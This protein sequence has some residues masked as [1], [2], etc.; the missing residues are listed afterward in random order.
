MAVIP[1]IHIHN[2]V[3]PN[4]GRP[5]MAGKIAVIG[6]FDS[7][8]TT[9]QLFYSLREAKE[10]LGTD[11]TFNGCA[12]L[13]NLFIGASS[14]LVL[15]TT[16]W[17]GSDENKTADK[18]LTVQKLS[19]ALAKIKGEDFD[20]LFVADVLTGTYLPI[21]TAFLDECYEMQCPAGYTGF[22]TGTVESMTNLAKNAGDHCYG[23][24]TQTFEVNEIPLSN[25]KSIAYYTGLLANS[26]VGNSLTMKVVGAVTGVTPEY[27][28]EKGDAGELLVSAGI[29][30]LKCINR[31]TKE[32][33][34]VNSEQP[35]GFD[36]Y[37]NRV[38]DFVVKEMSLQGFL[39]ER[40]RESTYS[41]IQQ[42]LNRIRD[43]CVTTLDL[44]EDI[45][46]DLEKKDANCL[47]IHITS[48]RFA[49]IITTIN[50]YVTVEVE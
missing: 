15:N 3:T 47:D 13:D 37:I 6:A 35:N 44:L 14:L 19:D 42:E 32:F 21:I 16:V 25:L 1:S 38:R 43:K 17:S 24:L 9:P 5:G 4:N 27:T 31:S 36:I 46:Y 50:V 49:G 28:F 23:L 34:I 39:G 2:T 41:E 33:V 45:E 20:I 22:L 48:L 12:V 29:T 10:A 8:V 7:E 18:T 11:E 26:N 30:T 40:N